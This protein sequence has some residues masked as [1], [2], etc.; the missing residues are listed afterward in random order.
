MLHNPGAGGGALIFFLR[1]SV[2]SQGSPE[3]QNP[4]YYWTTI[5]TTYY[6]FSG[7]KYINHIKKP[8]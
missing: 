6:Y 5:D 8:I 1:V 2:S 3:I 7:E 4:K